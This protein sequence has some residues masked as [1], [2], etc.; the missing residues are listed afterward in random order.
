V[1]RLSSALAGHLLLAWDVV[2][3]IR[4]DGGVVVRAHTVSSKASRP[5]IAYEVI[6]ATSIKMY[7]L[8]LLTGTGVGVY[9]G[10]RIC[11]RITG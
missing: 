5:F 10:A 4:K 8:Y 3:D 1:G 6:K 7:I 11:V 2:F 9:V